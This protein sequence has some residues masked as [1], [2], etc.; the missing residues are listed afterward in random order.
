MFAIGFFA[1]LR[2]FSSAAGGITLKSILSLN[3]ISVQKRF[4]EINE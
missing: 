1:P 3:C 2:M 4:L